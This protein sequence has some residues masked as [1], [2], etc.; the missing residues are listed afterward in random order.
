MS[1]RDE[2]LRNLEAELA[3]SA[4]DHAVMAEQRRE[5]A[6]QDM[7]RTAASLPAAGS[8]SVGE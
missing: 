4:A 2:S 8:L 1:D 5:W 3:Q 6:E 7:L